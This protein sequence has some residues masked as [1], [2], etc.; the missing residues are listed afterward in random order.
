MNKSRRRVTPVTTQMELI[1]FENDLRNAIFDFR[2]SK[3]IQKRARRQ[4][5][6]PINN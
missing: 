1:H 4:A 3:K 5:Q 6:R 2:M